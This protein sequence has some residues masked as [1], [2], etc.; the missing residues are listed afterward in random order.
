VLVDLDDAVVLGAQLRVGQ[1]ERLAVAPI[2]KPVVGSRGRYMAPL[3]WLEL[4]GMLMV[5]QPCAG[6]QFWSSQ[7]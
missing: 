6:S 4:C 1:G 5:W 7:S 2:G 3:L